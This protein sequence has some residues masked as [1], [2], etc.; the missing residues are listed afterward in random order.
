[1]A[2][3]MGKTTAACDKSSLTGADGEQATC[4]VTYE[5]LNVPWS[6]TFKGS[7]GIGRLVGYQAQPGFGVLT[8]EGVERDFWN[9]D[10]AYGRDLRCA[11]LPKAE[12]VPLDLP[13]RYRCEY[14]TDSTEEKG[15]TV[16]IEEQV[17]VGEAGPR[18]L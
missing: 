3:A 1:M 7:T 6:V 4:T 15:K 12:L 13:T 18:V 14:L 5:G 11:D 17:T 2:Q 9:R 8:R 10:H 16:W